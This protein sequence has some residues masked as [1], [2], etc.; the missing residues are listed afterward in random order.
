MRFTLLK[1]H[2]HMLTFAKSALESALESANSSSGLD[3]SNADT[4]VGMS[5]S[6]DCQKPSADCL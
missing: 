6:A 2:T 1:A 3:A 5:S 4:P